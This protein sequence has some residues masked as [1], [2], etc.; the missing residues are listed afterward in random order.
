MTI[1]VCRPANLS[2]EGIEPLPS[3]TKVRGFETRSEFG[4]GR[5]KK[6]GRDLSRPRSSLATSNQQLRFTVFRRRHRRGVR[7][8][9]G[10][11]PDHVRVRA[12]ADCDHR[13]ARHR[14]RPRGDPWRRLPAAPVP[15]PPG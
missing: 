9:E 12:A 11:R 5:G 4:F 13:H 14:V 7:H 2:L 10:R 6:E 8:R 15:P 3:P 1:A